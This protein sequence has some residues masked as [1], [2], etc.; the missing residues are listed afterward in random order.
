ML[1]DTSRRLDDAALWSKVRDVVRG[2]FDA[3]RFAAL[4]DE[5]IAPMAGDK[6]TGDPVKAIDL[7]AKRFGINETE[8]ASVLR[9]LIEGG[10]LTRY[11]LF[12]AITRTAEDLDSYDRATEFE[13]LGGQVI[14][15]SRTDWK[16]IAEVAA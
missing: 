4:V 3:A 1:S 6:I 7:S 16:A 13:K 8:K 15:L 10:D 12:N 5:Q 2:A 9:H 14:E 11:G